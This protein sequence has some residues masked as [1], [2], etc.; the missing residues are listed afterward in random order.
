[1][2]FLAA[3]SLDS[4][5]GTMQSFETGLCG[6]M[7]QTEQLPVLSYSSRLLQCVLVHLQYRAVPEQRGLGIAPCRPLQALVGSH[8]VTNMYK[9][10]VTT[11]CYGYGCYLCFSRN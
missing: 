8:E 4:N 3:A 2:S 11:C 7:S 9:L 5:Y 6:S 10:T 1:M